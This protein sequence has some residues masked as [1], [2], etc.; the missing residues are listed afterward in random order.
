M[1]PGSSDFAWAAGRPR[2]RMKKM[3]EASTLLE[4]QQSCEH[5][6]VTWRMVRQLACMMYLLEQPLD[7]EIWK[8]LRGVLCLT[9]RQSE[10]VCNHA[11]L[12]D[13]THSLMRLH[14]G[15]LQREGRE[16]MQLLPLKKPA[17]LP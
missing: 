3:A 15:S 7:L 16:E 12:A 14:G 6:I 13:T 2:P 10:A 8:A 11:S 17:S 1:C 9:C 5:V 4:H